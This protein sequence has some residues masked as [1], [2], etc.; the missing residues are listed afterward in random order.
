VRDPIVIT[1]EVPFHEVDETFDWWMRQYDR[2]PDG[3][4]LFFARQLQPYV[5]V[6]RFETWRWQFEHPKGESVVVILGQSHSSRPDPYETCAQ[7]NRPAE[8]GYC[9]RITRADGRVPRD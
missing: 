5:T 6:E 9:D 8:P 2:D 1:I 4:Y 7:H 3:Q